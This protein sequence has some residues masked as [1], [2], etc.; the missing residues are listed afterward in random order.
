MRIISGKFKG[1]VFDPQ[2]GLPIRPTTDRAR[3]GLFNILVHRYDIEDADCLDLFAG[4]GGVTFELLSRGAASV[5]SVDKNF[6]CIDF[7][8][9]TIHKLG[10]DEKNIIRDDVARFLKMTRKKFDLIF[11]DPPYEMTGQTDLIRAVFE[12]KLLNPEGLL[13]WEHDSKNSYAQIPQLIETREYGKGA[14]SFFREV[15]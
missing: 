7:I 6:R 9:K 8:Q 13:V 14:F 2:P 12:N 10:E 15:K 11:A 3:E 5:V 1:R 4:A